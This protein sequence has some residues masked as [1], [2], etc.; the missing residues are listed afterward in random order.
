MEEQKE[1][2]FKETIAQLHLRNRVISQILQM[3]DITLA[4][5][6]FLEKVVKILEEA[7]HCRVQILIVEKSTGEMLFYPATSEDDLTDEDMEK[8]EFI[9]NVYHEIEASPVAVERNGFMSFPIGEKNDLTG[10]IAAFS[11]GESAIFLPHEVKLFNEVAILIKK[12]LESAV[13]IDDMNASLVKMKNLFELIKDLSKITDFEVLLSSVVKETTKILECEG[14]SVLLLDEKEENLRFAA[15]TGE[16]SE[17]LKG[18][19][20]PKSEG[21]AGWVLSQKREVIVNEVDRSDHFSSRTDEVGGYTTRNLMAVSLGCDH[22]SIGVMEAVNKING[23]DF[24]SQD[25]LY[26]SILSSEVAHIIERSRLYNEL[27]DAFLSTIT[28]LTD[29][30]EFGAPLTVQ[31]SKN[32]SKNAFDIARAMGIDEKHAEDISVAALL[33]DVGKIGVPDSILQKQGPL[34]DN[35]WKIVK[36]HPE[37][38]AKI[39]QPIKKFAQVIPVIK[40]HHERWDGTGYPDGLSGEQI[41]IGAR[42]VAVC[43]AF[44]AM[45]SERNYGR[46]YSVQDAI[47]EII[48][49]SGKQFDPKVVEV[50]IPILKKARQREEE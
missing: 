19:V 15:V 26:F 49:N 35:E 3:M 2:L 10:M 1:L 33:H 48:A 42:I 13:V 24:S 50:S 32:M 43:D 47:E 45:I 5:D 36:K 23:K 21:I 27:N 22:K 11:Y 4:K 9:A 7:I 37:I 44:D 38:G 16:A 40:S 28:A 20:F 17:K 31:H 18:Y 12:I 41:P 39:L 34:D 46:R 8:R 14:A 29:A 25:L 6:T 30:V